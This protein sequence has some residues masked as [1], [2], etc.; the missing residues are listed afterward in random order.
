M[1]RQVPAVVNVRLH[2]H[3]V[4]AANH[5]RV[6]SVKSQLNIRLPKLN[7]LPARSS[8]GMED[9]PIQFRRKVSRRLFDLNAI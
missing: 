3:A 7:L 4:D 8:P 5:S 6:P 1:R 9:P 2:H